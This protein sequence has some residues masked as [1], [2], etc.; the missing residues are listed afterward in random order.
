MANSNGTHNTIMKEFAT[1]FLKLLPLWILIA[2]WSVRVEGFM[3]KD[4]VTPADLTVVIQEIKKAP[5]ED[6]RMYL[7]QRFNSLEQQLKDI[8][9]EIHK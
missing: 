1:L 6:Y 8:K 7:D 3:G 9:E 5:S 4:Y 2:A